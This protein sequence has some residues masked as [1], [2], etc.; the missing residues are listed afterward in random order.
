MKI[1]PFTKVDDSMSVFCHKC[2]MTGQL[3]I[4]D[5]YGEQCW[6]AAAPAEQVMWLCSK[7]S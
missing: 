2:R 1:G 4:Y 3:I 5:G 7:C 6:Y